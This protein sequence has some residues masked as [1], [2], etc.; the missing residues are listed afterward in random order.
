MFAVL[1]ASLVGVPAFA[2]KPPTLFECEGCLA[3]APIREV[4]GLGD[5]VSA[6]D[7]AVLVKGDD[8]VRELEFL[9]ESTEWSDWSRKRKTVQGLPVE[10]REIGEYLPI[11]ALTRRG[12]EVVTLRLDGPEHRSIP[13]GGAQRVLGD[14]CIEAMTKA[15]CKS[16]GLDDVRMVTDIYGAAS[17]AVRSEVGFDQTDLERLDPKSGVA[18]NVG[19]DN[20]Q[21]L[22]VSG[23]EFLV[24]GTKV[25][26]VDPGDDDLTSMKK[27]CP[28]K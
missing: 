7:G 27:N 9:A 2:G 22:S 8:C 17:V 13:I 4:P 1:L 10:A 23:G 28:K 6:R 11:R 20:P 19:L 12:K 24:V 5:L 3:Q 15:V 26:K 21:T 16:G 14:A 25:Q 18:W